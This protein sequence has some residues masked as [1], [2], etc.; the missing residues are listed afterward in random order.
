MKRYYLCIRKRGNDV[1]HCTQTTA[2]SIAKAYDYI[3]PLDRK[4]RNTDIRE[5]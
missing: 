1:W 5:G 2:T 4:P 3:I